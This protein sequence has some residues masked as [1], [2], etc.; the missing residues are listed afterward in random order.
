MLLPCMIWILFSKQ[1]DEKLNKMKARFDGTL[2]N[3]I[4]WV[5]SLPTA[6]GLEQGDI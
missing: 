2:D 6:G 4:Q 3:L 1:L 5:V